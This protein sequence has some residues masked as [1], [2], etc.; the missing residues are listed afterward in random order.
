MH[1]HLLICD[2]SF[3]TPVQVFWES[4]GLEAAYSTWGR[5]CAYNL[6]MQ[7]YD[8][9]RFFWSVDEIM[10]LVILRLF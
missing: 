9:A 2:R 3:D 5:I 1:Q 8:V 7:C 6:C 10:Y 4:P